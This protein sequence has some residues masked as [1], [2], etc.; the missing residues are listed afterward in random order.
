MAELTED[1]FA[2]VVKI[3]KN[4]RTEFS[5]AVMK[6]G[7]IAICYNTNLPSVGTELVIR[8]TANIE[9]GENHKEAGSDSTEY[10]FFSLENVVGTLQDVTE[11]GSITSLRIQHAD[12]INAIDSATVGQLIELE[13]KLSSGDILLASQADQTLTSTTEA[14]ADRWLFVIQ[15]PST[16]TDII[17]ADATNDFITLVDGSRTYRTTASFQVENTGGSDLILYVEAF[18]QTGNVPLPPARQFDIEKQSTTP[19]T[20]TDVI[21]PEGT[22]NFQF[23]YG[24]W[25]S[26]SPSNVVVK[27]ANVLIESSSGAVTSTATLQSVLDNGPNMSTDAYT[28]NDRVMSFLRFGERFF[29]VFGDGRVLALYTE[30]ATSL[31]GTLTCVNGS[32][33]QFTANFVTIGQVNTAEALLEVAEGVTQAE[34]YSSTSSDINGDFN[35]S[36]YVEDTVTGELFVGY[37]TW[38]DPLS[39]RRL[40]VVAQAN[41]GIA[42]KWALTNEVTP[43]QY[44]ITNQDGSNSYFQTPEDLA[45]PQNNNYSGSGIYSGNNAGVSYIP[46]QSGYSAHFEGNVLVDGDFVNTGTAWTTGTITLPDVS[47]IWEIRGTADLQANGGLNFDSRD[48]GAGN[49]AFFSYIS[50][51]SGA[52]GTS[53]VVGNAVTGN[54]MIN[55]VIQHIAG[56]NY[57]QV[58]GD[59]SSYDGSSTLS[60]KFGT[61]IKTTTLDSVL[62][63]ANTNSFS[64]YYKRIA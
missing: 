18:T 13:N 44:S 20:I 57:W 23:W 48:T 51:A 45:N 39:N 27:N 29:S 62:S 60:H 4:L 22:D 50:M 46:Q 33:D 54:N 14:T 40:R 17:D 35:I 56:T 12:G 34:S 3:R 37:K 36:S 7:Q 52:S 41:G 24:V 26:A 64:L 19:I 58:E 38:K 6:I 61:C 21:D 42:S 25:V 32:A 55:I 47:G 31:I 1:V 30:F 9:A 63:M 2:D 59:V 16:N 49:F 15:T 28:A 8:D 53:A 11:R 5:G 43:T 10:Y